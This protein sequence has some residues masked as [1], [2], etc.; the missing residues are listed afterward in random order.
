[1]CTKCGLPTPASRREITN[2]DP[3]AS[4]YVEY[5]IFCCKDH[6]FNFVFICAVKR[7]RATVRKMQFTLGPIRLLT[8]DLRRQ[9]AIEQTI[10][11]AFFLQ[12][13]LCAFF[14]VLFHVASVLLH[15][16]HDWVQNVDSVIN[17]KHISSLTLHI[18]FVEDAQSPALPPACGFVPSST[19]TYLTSISQEW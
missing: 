11:F 1:M 19:S 14:H 8:V 17:N 6:W 18:K 3:S 16:V 13:L 12:Q 15:H 2:L 4:Y 10:S 5:I 9:K 7:S